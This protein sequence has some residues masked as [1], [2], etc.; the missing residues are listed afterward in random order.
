MIPEKVPVIAVIS[1]MIVYKNCGWIYEFSYN[2]S[3]P[4][5]VIVVF[6]VFERI[7]I[8]ASVVVSPTVGIPSIILPVSIPVMIFVVIVFSIKI[9]V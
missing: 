5:V 2:V 6:V 4:V 9:T 8:V 7:R 1:V 3:V